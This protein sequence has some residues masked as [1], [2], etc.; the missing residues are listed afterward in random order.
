MAIQIQNHPD[1]LEIFQK[2]IGLLVG[3]RFEEKAMVENSIK[4]QDNIRA[5]IKGGDS[6]KEVR[7]WREKIISGYHP[8]FLNDN[9]GVATL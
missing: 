8:K 9:N 2:Q 4:V 3:A 1:N 7:K 6:V 5:K